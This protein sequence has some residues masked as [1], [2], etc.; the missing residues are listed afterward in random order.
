MNIKNGNKPTM[1]KAIIPK[2]EGDGLEQSS[3]M[4][5]NRAQWAKKKYTQEQTKQEQR[6]TNINTLNAIV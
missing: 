2:D 1:L 5:W 3:L 4:L 6:Q